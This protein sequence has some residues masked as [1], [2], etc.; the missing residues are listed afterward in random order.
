MTSE[1]SFIVNTEVHG[2]LDDYEDGVENKRVE[3]TLEGVSR[4]FLLNTFSVVA[5]K[6]FS[7]QLVLIILFVRLHRCF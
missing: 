4:F 3:G 7:P 2:S 1:F 6:K 5:L